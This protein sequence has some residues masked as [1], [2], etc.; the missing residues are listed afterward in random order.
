MLKRWSRAPMRCCIPGGSSELEA[1]LKQCPPAPDEAPAGRRWQ[2]W[3]I[4]PAAEQLARFSR[5][6]ACCSFWTLSQDRRA[7]ASYSDVP[8]MACSCSPRLPPAPGSTR[9]ATTRE[10]PNAAASCQLHPLGS[11]QTKTP[12]M[13]SIS[14]CILLWYTLGNGGGIYKGAI[15][16]R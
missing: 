7:T 2:D 15:I 16:R 13:H 9:C 8:S 4:Y 3:E 10:L 5:R 11:K 14:I 6:C 12:D 1:M